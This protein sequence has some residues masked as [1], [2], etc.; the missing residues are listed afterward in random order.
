MEEPTVQYRCGLITG[1]SSG[2]GAEFARQL[3]HSCRVLVLVA[4]RSEA[5]E[6]LAT[7]LRQSNPDLTVRCLP[8]DLTDDGQRQAL[9]GRM[10]QASLVPDL[11]I[12][13]AGMGDYGEFASSEW[14]KVEAMLRLN[15]EALTALTHAL[16]PGM[17][18]TGGGAIL[19]VSSLASLLPIPDFAVY[20][21][22]KAYVTSFSEALRL[23][24]KDYGLSVTALCPGPV[25]TGFGDVARR[26]ENRPDEPFREWF[27]VDAPQ[28]VAEALQGLALN[29]PRVFP[30][31]K[32]AGAAVLLG[33]LPIAILRIA[34]GSR[35][36]R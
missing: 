6:E 30:G 21:A 26:G 3:A 12:N 14:P 2:I 16:L 10:H 36:R 22:T 4:R 19:N 35:P 18:S 28:V 15:V 27:Y 9:V 5:L 24:L 13:N 11:V 34:M 7:E 1:A 25:H 31:W 32:I 8:A 23:E 33:L 29:R 20:A 17:I